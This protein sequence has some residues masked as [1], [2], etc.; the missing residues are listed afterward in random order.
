MQQDISVFEKQQQKYNFNSIFFSHTDQTPWGR[1]FIAS[2]THNPSWHLVYLDD[3]IA[4]FV[5]ETPT[6]TKIFKQYVNEQNFSF[7]KYTNNLPALLRLANFFQVASWRSKE[8]AAYQLIL[9]NDPSFCPALLTLSQVFYQ[10]QNPAYAIYS[11][12]YQSTCR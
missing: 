7:E 2:I 12:R 4:I 1:S 10:Q 11:S 3:L 5:R 6:N 9:E 8:I